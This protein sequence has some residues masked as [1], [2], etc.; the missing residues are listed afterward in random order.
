MIP[1]P[2]SKQCLP[3]ELL[4]NTSITETIVRLEFRWAGPI[5]R[6]GQF[7]MIRPERTSVF[8]GRP[9]SVA[10]WNASLS[11]HFLIAKRGRGTEEL[12]G[13]KP[14]EQAE[15]TGPLGNAWGDM[16]SDEGPIALLGGGIGIAPL[17][18]FAGELRDRA[19]DFYAGFKSASFGLEGLHPRSLI[20]AS[21]DGSVGKQGLIPDFLEPAQ[22]RA[23]YVCGP[24][25]ML[26]A[27]A[28]SCKKAGISC[29][30]S[31]ERSM[32]CGVGACLG[33]TIKTIQGK[34][35]CCADGPIFN[36]E[37]LIFDE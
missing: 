33:C 4:N 12:T 5:P 32:A 34:R 18:A 11:V 14:G 10:G 31:M 27:A 1:V 25:P 16:L 13:L 35:R 8:L 22:Y 9:I 3:G 26:K 29:F 37:E 6:A 36:A 15:L 28:G 24:E 2:P 23:V 7:F 19:Y 20:I 21:E 30:I 17:T